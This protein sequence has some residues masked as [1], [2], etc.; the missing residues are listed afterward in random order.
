MTLDG[1]T[2]QQVWTGTW[3]ADTHMALDLG[4]S[5]IL[6]TTKGSGLQSL[7]LLKNRTYTL[8]KTWS[9]GIIAA[10]EPYL[11]TVHSG[12]LLL[13]DRR[14]PEPFAVSK[15]PYVRKMIILAEN[16]QVSDPELEEAAADGPPPALPV[17]LPLLCTPSSVRCRNGEGCVSQEY[18]C[19]GKPD[20]QDGSDEGACSR[21]CNRPGVFQ[22]LN[23]NQCIEEKYHCDGAQQCSD[24]SDELGCWKPT[25]DCSLRCDNKTR[26]IP[27]RWLCDGNA[28]CSDE[29]DEQGCVHAECSAPEFRCQNGQCISN[30]LRCDGNQDCVDH[31]DGT[32]VLGPGHCGA[33]W[34]R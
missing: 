27:K 1:K 5:S 12:A 15:E 19:D 16:Q 18:L 31:S 17:A 29:R 4:S 32:A 25:E 20:C 22:C 9:D 34:G 24:G 7:S 14:T 23:R 6:W 26:C 8:N 11:A 13:W 30:S 10:H 21:F 28:D 33:R 2:R 3:T